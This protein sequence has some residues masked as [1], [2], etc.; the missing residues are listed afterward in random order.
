MSELTEHREDL[1][2]SPAVSY[3]LEGLRRCWQPE[4]ARY[5]CRYKF[6]GTG[7][8]NLSVP[9]SDA[10]YTLNVLLGFSRLRPILRREHGDVAAVYEG[11]CRES[12]NPKFKTYA[13]GMALW[14]G[15]E[16]GLRPPGYLVDR[17][18][19]ILSSSDGLRGAYRPRHRHDCLGCDRDDG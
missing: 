5:S 4:K 3:A 2:L 18:S 7:P 17:V 13:L 6:D 14:A 19:S 11:C 9:E 8:A 12:D 16:V 1:S 10:F 15:A